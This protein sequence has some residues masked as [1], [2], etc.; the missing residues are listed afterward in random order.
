MAP[1]DLGRFALIAAITSSFVIVAMA[2]LVPA[3][4]GLG[5]LRTGDGVLQAEDGVLRAEDGVLRAGV[6]S[7]AGIDSWLLLTYVG[8]VG[9][10]LTCSISSGSLS[11]RAGGIAVCK[12]ALSVP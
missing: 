11:E 10:G 9:A 6:G 8:E 2:V 12:C 4:A 3:G 5:L 7:L 1:V